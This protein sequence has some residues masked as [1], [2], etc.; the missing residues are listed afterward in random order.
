MHIGCK[1]GL[2][3]LEINKDNPNEL[4]HKTA[5]AFLAMMGE[6]QSFVIQDVAA[7]N[8]LIVLTM[9]YSTSS[10]SITGF[11]QLHEWDETSP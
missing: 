1:L 10:V 8:F 9:F 7:M 3:E 5:Q 4:K 2:F 6:L 11:H